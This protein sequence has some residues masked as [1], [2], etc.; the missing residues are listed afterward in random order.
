MAKGLIIVESPAKAHTIS[1]FLHHQYSVKAS[2]GHIRDLPS[3][4]MGVDVNKQF[5]PKYV[6]DPKKSKVIAELREAAKGADAIYLA[7]DHDREG[8]AIAWHLSKV[9]E[10]EIAGKPLYR[11]VFNEITAKAIS[12]AISQP[13]TLDMAKVDA[14]QARRVLDRIVGYSIS[15]LLWKVIAKDLSAGRVQSV[16]LRLICEREEEV[17]SFVPKEYWKVEAD[18]WRDTLPKF[19]ASLE[20]YDGKKL[21]LDTEADALEIIS[22]IKNQ[23]A[24]LSEIKRS[25]RNVEP[26]APFITSTLQQEAAR[27]L[28]YATKKTMIIAQQLYEGIDV[29]GFGSVGLV[30]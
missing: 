10:K 11:I 2:M 24:V 7:S 17:K 30:T 1:K 9:L 22:E 12:A 6:I 18:F 29:K 28:G 5:K 26:P 15:P 19:K 14:Q 8:E 4:E 25:T 20:K 3:H 16:A 27:K 21:E 13:G 23:E